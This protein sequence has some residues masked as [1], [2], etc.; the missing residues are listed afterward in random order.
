MI[1]AWVIVLVALVYFGVLF[2][3]AWAGDRYIR[4][5]KSGDGRPVTYALSL[6]VYCTSWTFFG[7]V[8][9]AATT[10]FDFLPVYL[11]PI[12]MF[13][14]GW[15]LLLRILRLA[16]AQNITSIADFLSA[17]YG[18][19]QAVGAIVTVIAVL[20]TLPYIALQLKAVVISVDTLIG[21]RSFA[22]LDLPETSFVDTAFVV[23]LLL[24]AFAI[25][26][27]T[28]HIDATEHQEGLMLAIAL[29]SVIK[30]AAF[31]AVGLFVTFWLFDG[32]GEL[33]DKVSANAETL[34]LF[35]RSIN[36]GTWLT[37]TL[38]SFVCII[39]LPRQFHVAVVENTSEAEVRRARWLFPLYLVMINIFVVPIAMAGLLMLPKASV[40]ADTFM[41]AL[42]SAAGADVVMMIAFIGGIS[43]ATAM[44]IVDCV[45]LS[46]MVC[47][48]LAVPLVLRRRLAS[49]DPLEDTDDMSSALL[50]IRRLAIFA[51]LLLGY[52]F[53]RTLGQ[54]HGLAQ[55]GLLSFSAIA[56][57]APAFFGGLIW[58]KATARGAIAGILAGFALWSYTLLLPWI[59]SGGWLPVS[60]MTEGPFGIS[61]LRP[62]VLFFLKF[63]PLTHGV[64]WSLSANILAFIMVSLLRAPEPVERLQANM[65]V[66]DDL[67]RTE[68]PGP[69][70]GLW[71]S[72]ITVEELQRTAARYLGVERARR[73]FVQFAA[74]RSTT[75]MPNAVADI[76][77]LR[78]TE[79]LLASAIGAASSRLVLSLLLRR[80]HVGSQSALKLLD[81]ATEALQYNRGLLQSAL[82]QVGQ[83]LAVFDKD[84]Q[85]IFWNRQYG[86]MLKLPLE[87]RGVGVPLDRILRSMAER[88]I[89]GDDDIEANIADRVYKLAVSRETFQER[90]D[91]GAR[92]L[93]VRTSPMPQGGIV[94]TYSDISDRVAASEELARVNETLERR[95]RERTAE[96]TSV[97][98]E[99]ER[100]RLAADAANLD[101]TRFIAAASHDI[102]Q[103]LNA[104]R[105]YASSLA[106]R[107]LKGKEA[108]LARNVDASLLAVEEIL[109]ALID[110]SRLDAQR[111]EPEVS[112]FPLAE[113]L[114]RLRV[115]FEPAARSKGLELKVV[116][117][118]AWVRSDRLL[119][120][121][122]LQNLISNAIKYTHEGKVLLGVRRRGDDIVVQVSDT[123]VGIKPEDQAQIFKEFQRIEA[124]AGDVRGLGLGLSIVERIGRV[125]GHD[126]RLWSDRGHG[127]TFSVRM[128]RAPARPVLESQFSSAGPGD[129][130]A[131][132][133]TLC[134]DNEPAVLDSMGELLEGWGCKVLRAASVEE[135]VQLV[136]GGDHVNRAGLD[137]I[138]A[139]YHL[140]D[141]TGIE[142]I[143]AIRKA[144]G[145]DVPALVIT[146]DHTLD[147]Q[148]RVR[149]MGHYMLR[150]PLKT[151]ALRALLSRLA[152]R[153]QAA[154]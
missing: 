138:L 57:F 52:V 2:A 12:L 62:N 66:I 83:G 124:D 105:L 21:T 148:R 5:R 132:F 121:R 33:I 30:L 103:P 106:E 114:E 152:V 28:R 77:L 43:A 49:L 63:D 91:G 104:A 26:F 74:G 47:N 22:A 108:G 7:S 140:D 18:K 81:D 145:W 99:L 144:V 129:S 89:F 101:K 128:P 87:L 96:L 4:L 80:D 31:L 153:R 60:I 10:G 95:V 98:A 20:G 37:I 109:G 151:P 135:A 110:I 130:L 143:A 92:I 100:A 154:E 8:G 25:L 9:L 76:G 142:A 94:T 93:E 73:S 115:E 123:G 48:N 111:M 35:S 50:R 32:F 112:T 16:K 72:S 126:V 38:L 122:M 88:G 69:A 147:V 120:R 3:V 40:D 24:A 85:L 14:A 131:G 51:I 19:S 27:G 133:V 36:G 23:A 6:A 11:G 127:A 29:E 41:L 54:A 44:V 55:I 136:A 34:E 146:A 39:L 56:Q 107:Q 68:P 58:R 97:N 46:I 139:D 137:V 59:I 134:I 82:D 125:L 67:P 141:A 150:K 45:A 64:L 1:D 119:L 53:Y 79:H 15:P 78:F 84:M 75:L 65:F 71:R 61:L 117:T 116:S 42:P 102:L 13:L 118:S 113:L 149:D 17:R 86:E 90:L 70:F